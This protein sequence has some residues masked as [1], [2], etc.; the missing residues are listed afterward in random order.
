MN[1]DE[2]DM[3]DFM[4]RGSKA[5]IT[6]QITQAIFFDLI[7]WDNLNLSSFFHKQPSR[8]DNQYYYQQYK[9]NDFLVGWPGDI[10]TD[11]FYNPQYYA[12][13]EYSIDTT[14][15]GKHNNYNG[16]VSP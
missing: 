2:P 3:N 1:L 9:A 4:N 15:A 13:K 14:H 10:N 8:P 16:F 11:S 12:G 7:N 6:K 5:R